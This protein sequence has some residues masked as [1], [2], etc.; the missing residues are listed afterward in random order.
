M[1]EGTLQAGHIYETQCAELREF[2]E[3]NRNSRNPFSIT[4]VFAFGDERTNLVE[5]YY[6]LLTTSKMNRRPFCWPIAYLSDD[7][8]TGTT[9]TGRISRS[10]KL[11]RKLL[12]PALNRPMTATLSS[13]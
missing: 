12:L 8:R 6:L 3:F 2:S 10:K 9:P 5:A 11:L 13:S 7:G 4:W 1:S